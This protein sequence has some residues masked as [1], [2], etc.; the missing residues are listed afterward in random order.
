MAFLLS[1]ATNQKAAVRTRETGETVISPTDSL[2]PDT[3]PPG[4]TSFIELECA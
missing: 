3:T 4:E 1:E 2:T